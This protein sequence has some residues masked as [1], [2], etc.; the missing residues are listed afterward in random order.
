MSGTTYQPSAS[1]YNTT[2]PSTTYRRGS[3]Y[4]TTTTGGRDT[5]PYRSEIPGSTSNGT[6]YQPA[7]GRSISPFPADRPTSSTVYQ[8]Q[9]YTE[10]GRPSNAGYSAVTAA[11]SVPSST[12]RSISPFPADRPT[13]STVYQT[14]PYTVV[15]RPSNAGYSAVPAAASVPSTTVGRRDLDFFD[16]YQMSFD[17]F[18]PDIRKIIG[19]HLDTSLDLADI[20]V[21][22][23]ESMC[24]PENLLNFANDRHLVQKVH[25]DLKQESA[26]HRQRMARII[27]ELKPKIPIRN[28]TNGQVLRSAL[29][30]IQTP[31]ERPDKTSA[32]LRDIRDDLVI[33]LDLEMTAQPLR[34]YDETQLSKIKKDQLSRKNV[35][36]R[37]TSSEVGQSSTVKIKLQADDKYLG[38]EVTRSNPAD[39]VRVVLD[40][41]QPIVYRQASPA[42]QVIT[43]AR[44]ADPVVVRKSKTPTKNKIT[45]SQASIE[46]YRSLQK[47]AEPVVVQQEVQR[48]FVPTRSGA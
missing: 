24:R 3:E 46:D 12:G 20:L 28:D 13:S 16:N 25:N 35:V 8:T 22:G 21:Y 10:V 36:S 2:G 41:Q 14:Q 37:R 23:H 34:K 27:E 43:V 4:P 26:A 29:Q 40:K 31:G 1:T 48:S 11:A 38:H 19:M 30:S 44:P 6:S 47:S 39:D 9:P 15:G 32:Q 45:T 17:D 33:L 18:T 5:S 7:T 42:P